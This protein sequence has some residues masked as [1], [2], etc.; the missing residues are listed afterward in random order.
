M[1]ILITGGAGYIGSHT[2]TE[3]LAAGEEIVVLDNF[4]NSSP[5]AIDSISEITGKAFPFYEADILDSDALRKIFSENDIE[6]VIHFAALKSIAD[7]VKSPDIYYKNNVSGTLSLL[8]VMAEYGCKKM[9]FSSS[10]SVYGS[11]LSVPI[12]ETAATAPTN[13]YGE[14]KVIIENKLREIFKSDNEWGV[15]ILRYFNPIGSHA[16]GL[17]TEKPLDAP[18]NLLP[19]ILSVVSGEKE[20]LEIYGD[21]YPTPDGTCIRDYIHITDLTTGHIKALDRIRRDKGVGIWNLGT[22]KGYSVLEIVKTF[23]NVCGVK[24]PYTMS[25]RRNGD[26]AECFADTSAAEKDLGWKAVRNIEE[27]CSDYRR[28]IR[29]HK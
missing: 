27:M 26:V 29:S 15:A 24:I 12:K 14:T 22:G 19:C 25:P 6:A 2:C 7:S 28:E 5:D 4:S 8:G 13:P 18:S 16:S 9:V 17:L 11:P 3:L 20:R 23:E 21:D 1:S 10:A